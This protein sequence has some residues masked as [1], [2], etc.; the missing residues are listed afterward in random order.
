VEGVAGV[1]DSWVGGEREEDLL[2][3]GGGAV[4]GIG[5][6]VVVVPLAG[7]MCG[8]PA[9]RSCGGASGA[10]CG[11]VGSACRSRA[12]GGAQCRW[13]RRG[14]GWAG[15]PSA[16]EKKLRGR[17]ALQIAI[18]WYFLVLPPYPLS[19]THMTGGTSVRGK[20]DPNWV[21]KVSELLA[22]G[23]PIRALASDA[24]VTTG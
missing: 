4:G 5:G 22:P 24:S 13:A 19:K 16:G 18:S 21:R 17:N 1:G 20:T 23:R 7:D 15:M 10:R 9:A 3:G 2:D 6:G 14:Y 12:G 8:S 11:W